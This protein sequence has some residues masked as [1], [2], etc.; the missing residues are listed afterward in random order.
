MV[1]EKKNQPPQ[2]DFIDLEKSEF[3]KKTNIVGFLIKYLFLGFLFFGLG[4]FVSN[5]YKIPIDFGVENKSNQ[6]SNLDILLD[7]ENDIAL[8]ESNIERVSDKI[9]NSDSFY[10]NL[11]NKNKELLLK[12]DE[13]TERVEK[14]GEFDYTS[15]FRKELNQYELLKNLMILKNRF[16]TRQSTENEISIIGSFFEN[17]FEVLTLVNF[18]N[19]IDLANIVKKDYLL[20]EINKKIRKYDLKLEDF[21]R[22]TKIDDNLKEK[23]IF[24][25]KEDFLSYLNDIFNST[26]KITKYENSSFERNVSENGN[27]RE[28][29]IL[30]KEYLITGNVNQAIKIVEQS[31]IDLLEYK[32]WLDKAKKLSEVEKNIENLEELILKRLVNYNDQGF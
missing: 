16:N 30:S 2:G 12:L 8:L 28:I 24:E 26:F 15:S 32:D 22:E 23:K 13:I 4:F 14:V 9:K 19:E 27:Y 21:F 5:K 18:F 17:D 7:L 25:S 10:K 29:L 31:G 11:E 20:N 1:E 6:K 3:K